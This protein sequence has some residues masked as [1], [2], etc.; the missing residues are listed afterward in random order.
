MFFKWKSLITLCSKVDFECKCER[1]EFTAVQANEEVIAKK[2]K[3]P[4]QIRLRGKHIK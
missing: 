3:D 2:I 1:K 4:V